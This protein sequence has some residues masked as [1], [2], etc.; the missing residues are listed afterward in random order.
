MPDRPRCAAHRASPAVWRT[1]W[2]CGTSGGCPVMAEQIMNMLTISPACPGCQ[3]TVGAPRPTRPVAGAAPKPASREEW[4][5]PRASGLWPLVD[6]PPG[7]AQR[8]LDAARCGDADFGRHAD[9][10]LDVM[11]EAR[12]GGVAVRRSRR[13]HALDQHGQRIEMSRARDLELVV[14]RQHVV[15]QDQ[16]L[17]LRREH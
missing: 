3:L 10:A 2:P 17:D 14:R 16:F 9:E 4:R 1:R 12:A 15:A 13:R 11:R 5:D 7:L 6:D 8:A